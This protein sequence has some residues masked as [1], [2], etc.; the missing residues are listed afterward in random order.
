MTYSATLSSRL[1]SV[2]PTT[3]SFVSRL[4]VSRLASP[5]T[6]TAHA[7]NICRRLKAPPYP[8]LV[9]ARPHDTHP[10]HSHARPTIKTI[11]PTIYLGLA[12]RLSI[13]DP[14]LDLFLICSIISHDPESPGGL[15]PTRAPRNPLHHETLPRPSCYLLERLHRRPNGA[16]PHYTMLLQRLFHGKPFSGAPR[17][18]PPAQSLNHNPGATVDRLPVPPPAPTP[19]TRTGTRTYIITCRPLR[20]LKGGQ[21]LMQWAWSVIPGTLNTPSLPALS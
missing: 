20:P 17:L 9:G 14:R 16:T 8:H 6:T 21:P 13:L 15:P 7:L 4:A 11:S 10:I 2:I 1:S 18:I 5:L 19:T 3:P 12:H